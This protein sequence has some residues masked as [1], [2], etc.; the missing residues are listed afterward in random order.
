MDFV[1]MVELNKLFL[2]A[3]STVFGVTFFSTEN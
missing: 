2:L 3:V 1:E